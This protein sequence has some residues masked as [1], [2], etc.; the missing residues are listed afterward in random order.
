MPCRECRTHLFFSLS[1]FP[2]MCTYTRDNERAKWNRATLISRRLFHD[3]W[4]LHNSVSVDESPCFAEYRVNVTIDLCVKNGNGQSGYGKNH[5]QLT[6]DS[7]ARVHEHEREL[8]KRCFVPVHC[9]SDKLRE[10]PSIARRPT[11]AASRLPSPSQ[12]LEKVTNNPGRYRPRAWT[13][14]YP[15]KKRISV[16]ATSVYLSRARLIN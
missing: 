6:R 8:P 9:S 5:S 13:V 3:E 12:R 7:L 16:C 4:I 14:L 15:R 10:S 2:S 1:S 11:I